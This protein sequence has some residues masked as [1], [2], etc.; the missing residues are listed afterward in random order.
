MP[1]EPQQIRQPA[2]NQPSSPPQETPIQPPPEQPTIVQPATSA[3]QPA[4]S[5]KR[6]A[7]LVLLI[8]VLIAA[9]G[10]LFY[11]WLA[12]RPKPEQAPVTVELPKATLV[13]ATPK[14]QEATTSAQIKV[15]GKTNS[16]SLVTAYTDTQEETFESD[17]NGDFSGTLTLD[18]GPNEIT[19]TAFGQDAEETSETRSVVYVTEKEL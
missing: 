2:D 18:E 9:I 17:E 6:S 16:A 13:L 14:D 12:S 11:F 4:P 10:T 5:S 8:V 1:E 19:V 3:P 7:F 15:S